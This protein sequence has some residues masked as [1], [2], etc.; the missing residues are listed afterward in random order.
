M[1]EVKLIDKWFPYL[2]QPE[3]GEKMREMKGEKTY[4]A[5]ANETGINEQVL[6]RMCSGNREYQQ[7]GKKIFLCKLFEKEEKKSK[8]NS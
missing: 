4:R 7:W 1:K 8:N 6:N 3:L 2:Q 5:F